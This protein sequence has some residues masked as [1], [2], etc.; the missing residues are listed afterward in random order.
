MVGFDYIVKFLFLSLK[1]VV[2]TSIFVN[3]SVCFFYV[4]L[5][6]DPCLVIKIR[7]AQFDNYYVL[8]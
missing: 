4:K 5:T 6:F 8:V 3:L 1:I 2:N 7:F